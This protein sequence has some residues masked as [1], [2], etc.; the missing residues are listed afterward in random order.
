[1]TKLETLEKD[2]KDYLL[3]IGVDEVA[4]ETLVPFVRLNLA[5]YVGAYIHTHLNDDDHR[6]VEAQVIKN[7]L[8][9]EK[10]AQMYQAYFE[11]K[12]GENLEDLFQ[13]YFDSYKDAIERSVKLFTK[14]IDKVKTL[15]DRDQENELQSYFGHIEQRALNN[16]KNYQA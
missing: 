5:S 4:M 11:D 9:E 13:F 12:T 7:D 15:P 2:F 1:M 3:S 6:A 14:V 16:I 8:D 10:A